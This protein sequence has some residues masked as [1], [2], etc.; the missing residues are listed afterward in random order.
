MTHCNSLV[1]VTVNSGTSVAARLVSATNQSSV[2]SRK[3]ETF[4]LSAST[5]REI[6]F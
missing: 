2:L 6:M 3:S 5:N 1:M 4:W